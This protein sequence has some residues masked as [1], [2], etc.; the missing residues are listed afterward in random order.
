VV[1]GGGDTAMDCVRT[2][3]RDG[4]TS[5][6]CLYR[7]DQANMPGSRKEFQNAVEEGVEFCFNESPTKVLVDKQGEL[8]GINMVKTELG[9]AGPDGRQRIS[10]IEGSEQ[11]VAADVIIMA[12]G[13]DTLA[14]PGLKEAGVELGDWGQLLIDADCCRTSHPRVYAGGDCQR[15]ADLVVTAAA[16]GRRA[17][18][19][20]MTQLLG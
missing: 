16:D 2:A 6:T 15:G 11:C 8:I 10:V 14:I 20:M 17:A 7:R 19:A 18:L 13:F 9:A 12:L 1:I 4:A 3:I 5:V